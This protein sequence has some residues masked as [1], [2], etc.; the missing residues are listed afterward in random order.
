MQF[1]GAVVNEQ[2][3]TFGIVI[4]KASVLSNP[5]KRAEIRRFGVR[6][7][8]RMPIVLAAQDSRGV[9]TYQGRRDI[10]NFLA[11]IDSSR[12]PWKKWTIS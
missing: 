6:A 7:W 12:I 11:G 5:T 1:E 4:V 9:F 8:G 2:G 10:V 3:Q